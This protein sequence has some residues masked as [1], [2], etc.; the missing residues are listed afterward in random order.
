VKGHVQGVGYRYFVKNA[1]EKLGLRGY[2][3]NLDDGAVEVIA[4]G[5]APAIEDLLGSLQRGPRLAEVRGV[6]HE[7]APVS[8]YSSFEIR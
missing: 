4:V 2:A 5:P 3:R 7:P 6:E 1:A 8:D